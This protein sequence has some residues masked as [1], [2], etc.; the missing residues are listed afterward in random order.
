LRFPLKYKNDKAHFELKPFQSRSKLSI[1]VKSKLWE[2]HFEQKNNEVFNLKGL[3]MEEN[4][5]EITILY[6]IAIESLNA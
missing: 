5:F 4:L 1:F 2:V 3:N 6:P